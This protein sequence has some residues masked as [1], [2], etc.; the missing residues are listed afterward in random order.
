MDFAKVCCEKTARRIAEERLDLRQQL[1]VPSWS[2]DC[3]AKID[4]AKNRDEN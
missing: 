1:P 2:R 4:K 3:N